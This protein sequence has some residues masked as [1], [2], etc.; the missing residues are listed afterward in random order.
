MIPLILGKVLS[1]KWIII[2][3]AFVLVLAF[4]VI[5]TWDL[6]AC[7]RQFAAVVAEYSAAFQR[8]NDKVTEWE[9]KAREAQAKSTLA[10]KKAEEARK[11]S[12][13]KVRVI[14]ATPKSSDTSTCIERENAIKDLIRQY[15]TPS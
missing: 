11:A 6:R 15:R 4:G 3:A 9:K 12:E 2:G 8:Q 7:Q 1:N 5:Q 14:L 10:L 13:D